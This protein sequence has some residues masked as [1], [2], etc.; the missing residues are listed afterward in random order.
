MNKAEM[1]AKLRGGITD[2]QWEALAEGRLKVSAFNRAV[3]L[4]LRE[5]EA[6]GPGVVDEAKTIGLRKVT[7][8]YLRR[9]LPEAPEAWQWIITASLYLTFIAERPM[10]PIDMLHITV[11]R[12]EGRMVYECPAKSNDP[13]TTCHYCVCKGK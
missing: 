5:T 2:E 9:Y 7:E 1:L 4:E 6:R 11:M 10:H 3:L 12:D 8:D 13:N